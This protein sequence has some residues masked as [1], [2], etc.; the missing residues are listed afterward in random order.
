[1]DNQLRTHTVSSFDK[2]LKSISNYIGSMNDLITGSIRTFIS[3]ISNQAG[4]TATKA[5]EIDQQVNELE[6]RFCWPLWLCY[7]PSICRFLGPQFSWYCCWKS[8]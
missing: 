2:E 1:M 3:N 5:R 4:E 8:R 7:W 6:N